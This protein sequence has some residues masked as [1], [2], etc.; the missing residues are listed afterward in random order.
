MSQQDICVQW[1]EKRNDVQYNSRKLMLIVVNSFYYML[2]PKYWKC[3]ENFIEKK[4]P[5]IRHKKRVT[6]MKEISRNREC[7][8]ERTREMQRQLL[9]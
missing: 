7:R 2:L 1:K 3:S 6:I 5:Y 4:N 9:M 8:R